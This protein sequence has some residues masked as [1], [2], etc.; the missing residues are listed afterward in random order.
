MKLNYKIKYCSIL[1]F[2]CLLAN[3][4]IT[5]KSTH[6]LQD[7]KRDYAKSDYPEYRIQQGDELQV[8]ITSLDKE[9]VSIFTGGVAQANPQSSLSYIVYPDGT[10]DLFFA[11]KIKVE[12][13]TVREAAE[14]IKK[15]LKE[16]VNNELS[17]KV[18]MTNKFYYII[19]DGQRKGQFPVYKDRLTIFEAL[20]QGG[21]LAVSANRKKLKVL[22]IVE[23]EE[24]IIE[25]DLRSKDIIDSEYYYILPNDVIYADKSPGSFFRITSFSSFL[26]VITSTISFVLLVIQYS[27]N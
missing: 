12:G 9:A 3:S 5:N 16:Y 21:D 13:L 8:L 26:G 6:Y 20:A 27:V 17:V 25:F 11:R 22:R 10:I 7:I 15:I 23:N 4:C 1:F 18:A 2:V 24:K 19:G 14:K